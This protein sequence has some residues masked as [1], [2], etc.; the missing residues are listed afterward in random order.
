MRAPP[1]LA[2]MQP[3]CGRNVA[4]LPRDPAYE[5]TNTTDLDVVIPGLTGLPIRPEEAH[6]DSAKTQLRV[7]SADDVAPRARELELDV[8]TRHRRRRRNDDPRPGYGDAHLEAVALPGGAGRTGSER[9]GGNDR[10]RE[11]R[12]SHGTLRK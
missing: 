10:R 6:V 3:T 12:R 7:D 5:A 2:G 11:N 8:R 9:Q 1:P 4:P